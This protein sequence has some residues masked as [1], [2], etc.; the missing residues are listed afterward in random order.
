MP[1]LGICLGLQCMVIEYARNVAGIE[2]A[3]S[4][5]FDPATPDPVIS[6]MEAQKAIVDGGGDLGGTMRLGTQPA[7][8]VPGSIVAQAYAG[9]P[10]SPVRGQ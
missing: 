8:L 7:D 6:T 1:T 2:Q 9:A 10:P 3:S 5:E 4:A